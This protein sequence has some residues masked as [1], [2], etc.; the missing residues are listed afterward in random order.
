V[1]EVINLADRAKRVR[2]VAFDV[3]GV[4][5]DGRLYYADGGEEIKAFDVQDGQGIKMLRDSGIAVAIITSRASRVVENRARDLGI[6]FCFQGVA[7]KLDTMNGLLRR[8]TLDMPAAGY[9]GDDV[10][11]LPVL[12]R[13]G[14]AASVPD[15][16]AIVRKHAHY[17]TRAGGGRGAVREFSEFVLEAQG[18]LDACLAAYLA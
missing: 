12:R 16:P 2:L 3:D 9:M 5:T 7:N 8:L 15:A 14:L 17:V 1:N 18:A 10:I 4:L 13:C 6:E 11:D